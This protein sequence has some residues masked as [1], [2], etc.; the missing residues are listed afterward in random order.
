MT[1]PVIDYDAGG[2]DYRS[3]WTAHGYEQWAEDRALRRHFRTL[4]TPRWLADFGGGFGRNA[5]H[6]RYRAR[7]YVIADYSSTNLTNA[8]RLLADDVA[9]GRAYLVRC[10]LN[11]LP[12]VDGA[13]DASLVVRVLH[14]LPDLAGALA[15]MGRTTTGTWLIDVPIKH[16]VFGVVRGAAT[17]NLAA[18]RDARPIA[19]GTTGYPFWNFSL[20]AVRRALADLG[21][22]TSRVASVNNL[23]RWD[24]RLPPWLVRGA[25]P[26]A[27]CAEAVLQPLGRGW[28]GPSQFLRAWRAVPVPAGSPAGLAELVACPACRGPLHWSTRVARCPACA[29]AYPRRGDH[30]DFT[31]PRTGGAPAAPVDDLS[32]A[33]TEPVPGATRWRCQQ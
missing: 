26:A 23:R 7:H 19:T 31:A 22:H 20:P 11:R 6:Y 24:R 1:V 13:F 14:H 21:W 17:G 4:G 25:T 16:H 15:E 32:R 3:Y 29:L 2:Y 33:M 30:W 27:Y 5:E 28:W 18:V 8:A 10:D 9:A 12:F